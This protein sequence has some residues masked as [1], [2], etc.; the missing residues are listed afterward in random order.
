MSED[1]RRALILHSLGIAA[2]LLNGAMPLAE[3]LSEPVRE[4]LEMARITTSDALERLR[5][6]P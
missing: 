4:Q 2:S 1:V 5:R 3:G 6:A